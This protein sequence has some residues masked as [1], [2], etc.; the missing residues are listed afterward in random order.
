MLQLVLALR[1]LRR[2]KITLFALLSVVLGATAFIVVM[3]VMDGYA[4]EFDSR[5]RNLLGD[6]IVDIPHFAIRGADD[7][8]HRLSE[9]P[10]VQ[11]AAANVRDYGI[12]KIPKDPAITGSPFAIEWCLVVGIDP[13]TEFRVVRP[14]LEPPLTPAD[15]PVPRDD[16]LPN[17]IILGADLM[18]AHRLKVGDKVWLVTSRQ[19]GLDRV[20]V[21]HELTVIGS[22]SFGLAESD[23]E[24]AYVDRRLAA[25]L[26]RYPL[27]CASEI[28]V[29]LKSGVPL[30]AGA[31]RVYEALSAGSP[32]AGYQVATFRQTSNMFK[33]IESQRSLSRFILFFLFLVSGLA[34][35]A[36]L[37][38]IV[39]QKRHD[40]GVLRSLGLSA[41]GVAAVFLTYAGSV[42]VVGSLLG[43]LLGWALLSHLDPIRLFVRTHTGFDLFPAD[44]YH[45]ERVPWVI[46]PANPI[47]IFAAALIVS[48][49]AGAVPALWAAKLDPVES[50]RND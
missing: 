6:L 50:L 2:R 8:V 10:E 44:L 30:D 37:F 21:K 7:K 14:R 31:E 34:V 1:Y 22:L 35:V 15:F 49:L 42:A 19:S 18:Q 25:S 5:S 12:L 46:E 17:W 28:R 36:V 20:N 16:E 33:A 40:I 9:L 39:L 41:R 32:A 24:V 27:D 4:V 48:L 23:R 26:R 11:A 43:C 47:M 45:L 3:G 38:L 13:D 29:R